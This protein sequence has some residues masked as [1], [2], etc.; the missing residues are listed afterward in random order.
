MKAYRKIINDFIS[1]YL[2]PHINLNHQPDRVHFR[3]TRT[4]CVFICQSQIKDLEII[5]K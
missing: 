5:Q 1:R 2:Q 3:F 4:L